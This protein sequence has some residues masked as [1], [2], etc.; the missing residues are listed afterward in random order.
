MINE[1]LTVKNKGG[2]GCAY[3][4]RLSRHLPERTEEI[5]EKRHLEQSLFRSRFEP[6]S[7]RIKVSSV[8]AW[9]KSH[10]N[11]LRTPPPSFCYPDNNRLPLKS[12]SLPYVTRI[13]PLVYP[14]WPDET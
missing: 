4:K 13:F 10:G 12:R 11:I 5:N 14:S 2:I 3:F 8:S 7:S 1:H 6:S 9:A